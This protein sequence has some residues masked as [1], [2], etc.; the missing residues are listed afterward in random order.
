MHSVIG[1]LLFEPYSEPAARAI[2]ALRSFHHV[3]DLSMAAVTQDRSRL[4][5][6]VSEV[7]VRKRRPVAHASLSGAFVGVAA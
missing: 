4:L 1:Q 3:V 2:A 5:P 7:A 6:S